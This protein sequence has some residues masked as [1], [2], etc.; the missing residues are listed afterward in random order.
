MPNL[1]LR[2][3][4]LVSLLALAGCASS[5]AQL[6]VQPVVM[7]PKMPAPAAWAMEP[8][9][10][11]QLLQGVFSIYGSPSQPMPPSSPTSRSTP[12]PATG[13]GLRAPWE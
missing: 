1:R 12:S 4:A 6:P 5:P 13:L 2:A 10:S 9:N 8:S 3:C 7:C 11:T